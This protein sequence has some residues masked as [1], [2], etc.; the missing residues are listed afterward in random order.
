MTLG[1]L[2]GGLVLLV[3]TEAAISHNYREAIRL[4]YAAEAGLEI[5]LGR[6][7]ALGDWSGLL[8][9]RPNAWSVIARGQLSDLVGVPADASDVVTI[10]VSD[11]PADPDGDPASDSNGRILIRAAAVGGRGGRAEAL[12]VAGRAE[13]PRNSAVRLLARQ[14]P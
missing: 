11:D 14:E 2:S 4:R 6:L 7:R 13:T 10:S 9:N 12:A 3:R 1:A 5:G 8:P